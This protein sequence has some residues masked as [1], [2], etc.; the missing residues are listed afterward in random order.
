MAGPLVYLDTSEVRE[1]AL[2]SIRGAIDDLVAFIERNEPD[3]LAYGVYLS[4]NGKRM[5]V[6]HVHMDTASLE[7]H[8]EVGGPAFKPFTELITL[9]TIEVYGEPSERA[10]EQLRDK[11]RMLGSGRVV[12]HPP[13][14]GFT[15]FG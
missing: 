11:A 9:S 2:E 6:V 7:Y 4:D 10:I 14:G 8:L 1:G 3:L 12:I 15:R 13:A 5:T